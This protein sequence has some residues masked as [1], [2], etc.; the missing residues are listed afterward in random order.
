MVS[1]RYNVCINKPLSKPRM[2]MC[3]LHRLALFENSKDVAYD[4]VRFFKEKSDKISHFRTSIPVYTQKQHE[5]P[6]NSKFQV[7]QS[8]GNITIHSQ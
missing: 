5:Y 7:A 3:W 2:Q 4:F 6:E 8:R 1:V